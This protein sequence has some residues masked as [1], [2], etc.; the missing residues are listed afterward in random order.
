[1]ATTHVGYG[2]I[3]NLHK[4]KQSFF[5]VGHKNTSHKLHIGMIH[6][7]NKSI[8]RKALSSLTSITSGKSMKTTKSA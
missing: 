4:L 2:S 3:Q 1:M 8:D 6:F 7:T 5:S